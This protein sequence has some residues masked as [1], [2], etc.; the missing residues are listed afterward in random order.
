MGT[1]GV[2]KGTD[3]V[4]GVRLKPDTSQPPPRRRR[5][6]A[7]PSRPKPR[8]PLRP[9]NWPLNNSFVGFRFVDEKGH[10][11]EGETELIVCTWSSSVK[12]HSDSS[13]EKPHRSACHVAWFSGICHIGTIQEKL[14]SINILE[15]HDGFGRSKSGRGI[16]ING[17]W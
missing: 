17:L 15:H 3:F 12:H 14:E 7:R 2:Q 16:C 4:S 5:P 9:A 10:G 8:P 6:R 13:R 1:L 11:D